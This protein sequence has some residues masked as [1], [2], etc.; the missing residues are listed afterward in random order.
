MQVF[1]W[2]GAGQAE[3]KWHQEMLLGN[4]PVFLLVRYF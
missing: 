2:G 3:C 1:F 4:F